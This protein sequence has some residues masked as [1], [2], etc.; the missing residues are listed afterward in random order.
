M[1]T[2]MLWD[3]YSCGCITGMAMVMS[4]GIAD[5]RCRHCSTSVVYTACYGYGCTSRNGMVFYVAHCMLVLSLSP[6]LV[7]VQLG[8]PNSCCANSLS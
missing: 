1:G 3:C 6:L 8:L 2:G 5:N 4:M 7:C